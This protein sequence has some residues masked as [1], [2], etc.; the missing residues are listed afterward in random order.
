MA[1]AAFDSIMEALD[2]PMVIVTTA[3]GGE[4]AGCLVGFSGQ[5][6]ISPP[7]YAVWLSKANRT[8]RLATLADAFAVHFLHD[9][10]RD[11]ARLFGTVSGDDVD[12]FA[13]CRWR[14]GPDGVPVLDECPNRLVGRKLGLFDA[15]TDHA[16]LVVEPAD[17]CHGAPFTPLR[18]G[19]VDD[20]APGHD[21]EDF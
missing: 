12:K 20:L 15:S 13:R 14:P 16:C 4:R 3:H 2:A 7:R 19:Q 1:D 10:H 9:S 21:A 18:L 11:L 8:Y 17:V 6:G 5:A